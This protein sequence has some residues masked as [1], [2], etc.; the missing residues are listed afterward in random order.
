MVYSRPPEEAKQKRSR[1]PGARL[2]ETRAIVVLDDRRYVLEGPNAVIGR[3][4]DCDCVFRDPNISRRHAELRRGPTGD[5]QIVDLGSTNGVKVNERRVDQ[6]AA[7]A[8][9][10]GRPRAPRASSST[11]SNEPGADPGRAGR[12]SSS[13]SSPSST[14][15]CCGWRGALCAS[16]VAP[17]P[18]RPRNGATTRVGEPERPRPDAWLIVE[19]GGG[20]PPG[21]RIDL[22]GGLSIGRS[23]NA[24]IRIEDRYASQI[25]RPGLRSRAQL[26]R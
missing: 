4:K 1:Q 10:R 9:G 25:A 12:R 8:G 3:S 17:P 22:F 19:A 6:L 13:A 7:V 21:E 11:S 26:L 14:C 15:S 23:P 2:V 5:W 16:C 18:R 24:D 20:L